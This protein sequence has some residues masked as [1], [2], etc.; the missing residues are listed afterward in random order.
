MSISDKADEIKQDEMRIEGLEP[1]IPE[2]CQVLLL[3]SMPS[4]KSLEQGFYYA[5]PQNRMFK[6]LRHYELATLEQRI[7]QIGEPLLEPKIVLSTD[8][9][10]A[11]LKTLKIGM[12]DVVK[13]CIRKGSLDSEIKEVEYADIIGILKEHTTI[14]AVVTA[15]AFSAKEFKKSTLKSLKALNNTLDLDEGR[16]PSYLLDEQRSFFHIALPS[17]SPAYTI[18][19][20]KLKMSFDKAL[21]PL[22]F[23]K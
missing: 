7:P 8:E 11:L 19:I 23:Q 22:L 2:N 1:F 15:G 18:K 10:K 16:F 9:C 14:K 17:T 5:N 3:G 21:I 4:V 13:S 20:D 6:I 12:Y